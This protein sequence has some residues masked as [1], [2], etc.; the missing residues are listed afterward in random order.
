MAENG[1]KKKKVKVKTADF[2]KQT[3]DERSPFYQFMRKEWEPSKPYDVERGLKYLERPKTAFDISQKSYKYDRQLYNKTEAPDVI[4]GN[5]NDNWKKTQP[6]VS[7]PVM[8]SYHVRR[9]PYYYMPHPCGEEDSR[10]IWE[11]TADEMYV[12][13]HS[14]IKVNRPKIKGKP[15][16][17]ERF[18]DTPVML[19]RNKSPLTHRYDATFQQKDLKKK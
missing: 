6:D 4:Y 8:E 3:R 5:S 15:D 2:A 12:A 1:P 16:P 10:P 18:I 17:I 14:S 9:D 11:I 7:S 13:S 19:K